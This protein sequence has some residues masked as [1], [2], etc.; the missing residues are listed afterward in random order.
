VDLH[1]P[2]SQR[3]LPVLGG[4][5][6]RKDGPD[7]LRDDPLCAWLAWT[8]LTAHGVGLAAAGLAVCVRLCVFV[9]VCVRTCVCVCVCVCSSLV[10]MCTYVCVCTCV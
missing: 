7:G 6:A 8:V 3:T 5:D 4:L 2:H 9:R 10:C 1:K